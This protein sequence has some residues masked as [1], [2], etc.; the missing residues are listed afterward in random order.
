MRIAWML[1]LLP[2]AACAFDPRGV[3]PSGDDDDDT[4]AP[5]ARPEP[6]PDGARPD[7]AVPPDAEPP[8]DAVLVDC[9]GNYEFIPDLGVQLR[10]DQSSQGTWLEAAE[11]CAN[12]AAPATFLAIAADDATNAAIDD[13]S[14]NR[15][16][17]IGISDAGVEGD[18]RTVFGD[19][20]VFDSWDFGEPN[21]GVNPQQED[22]VELLDG[23]DW[24]DA[25]CDVVRR[26][27]CACDPTRG[28]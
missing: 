26:Y 11:D 18:Y 2:L 24:N 13:I 10:F 14:A 17:W 19:A 20:I 9:P 12:D 7:A 3:P 6:D 1:L 23:G 16:I 21:D 27:V 5:D 8:P 15:D 22:C 25:S 28:R 4:T